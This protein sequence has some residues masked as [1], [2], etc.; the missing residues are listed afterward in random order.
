LKQSANDPLRSSKVV[1]LGTNRK[2]LCDFLL[3]LSSNLSPI[4]SRFRDIRAFVRL[5][6]LFPVPHS[7]SGS[8]QNFG[9]FSSDVDPRSWG[10]RRANTP[11]RTPVTRPNTVRLFSKNNSNLCYQ[12][13][14]TSRADRETDDLPWQ[15]R[16]LC[17]ASRGK[18]SS[19]Y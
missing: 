7:S 10:L 16:A 11:G 15:Y 14:S 6:P 5:K 3:V 9:V 12:G 8:G 4:L 18:K 2:R 19:Q 17:V 13:T 1:D